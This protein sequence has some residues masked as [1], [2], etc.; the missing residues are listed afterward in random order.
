V[1][2]LIRLSVLLSAYLT[3][4]YNFLYNKEAWLLV[5]VSVFVMCR[6]IAGEFVVKTVTCGANYEPIENGG[7]IETV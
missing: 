2:K 6:K 7:K 4:L 5:P 1:T 3:P